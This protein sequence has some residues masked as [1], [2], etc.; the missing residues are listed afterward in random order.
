MLILTIMSHSLFALL[1]AQDTHA[2]Q[3]QR[4]DSVVADLVAGCY[5]LE[6][7]GWRS[8]PA[9]ARI[10]N[11]PRGAIRFELTTHP[12]PGWSEL[13]D[14]EHV[15][16]EV[17]TD[18]IAEWGRGLFTS[19]VRRPGSKAAIDVS[20]PLPMAGFR[21]S[22]SPRGGDLVGTITA[23]TDSAPRNGTWEASHA[24]TA[25]RIACRVQHR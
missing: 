1:M 9:L 12:A 3:F 2:G 20:R 19:W 13:S 21:L 15:Y 14:S 8:D 11:L 17:R 18:S 23:F 24:V 10:E 7:G 25:R 22:V 6:D 16:F 4:R 5:E